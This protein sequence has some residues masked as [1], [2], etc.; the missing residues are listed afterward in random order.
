MRL[1]HLWMDS[2]QLDQKSTRHTT[3]PGAFSP[4]NT[5]KKWRFLHC[6]KSN[7]NLH[8][9]NIL[10][11]MEQKQQYS[12]NM[13]GF[14]ARYTVCEQKPD[15]SRWI[16]SSSDRLGFIVEIQIMFGTVWPVGKLPGC[17]TAAHTCKSRGGGGG[18]RPLRRKTTVLL[19]K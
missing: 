19:Q 8:I 13:S 12:T 6:P 9:K 5:Q 1:A 4:K 15:I 16:H 14:T 3:R 18:E 7:L 10:S 17:L 2:A 11:Q